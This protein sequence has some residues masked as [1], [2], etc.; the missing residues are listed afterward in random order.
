MCGI[1]DSY[2]NKLC[3]PTKLDCP[4]N[5]IFLSDNL[6][7]NNTKLSSYSTIKLQNLTVYYS[8]KE[9]TGKIING[10]FVD[11]DLLLKYKE[12]CYILDSYPLIDLIKDNNMNIYSDID[13][14]N[15]N[16]DLKS[17]LKW[18]MPFQNREIDLKSMKEQNQIFKINNT[19]N[20]YVINPSKNVGF[21]YAS[22]FFNLLMFII[23]GAILMAKYS[24]KDGGS[25]CLWF[26]NNMTNISQFAVLFFVFSFTTFILALNSII[27][28]SKIDEVVNNIR[29][30]NI[31]YNTVNFTTMSILNTMFFSLNFAFIGIILCFFCVACKFKSSEKYNTLI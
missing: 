3:L 21:I 16:S 28:K 10:L 6:N 31:D 11:S 19:I 7:N 14:S 24:E 12:G 27:Y 23:L 1:L 18:C 20:T 22:I 5:S 9:P 30:K 4:I 17:Y 15:L 26:Q 25:C 13:T 2:G 29:K 8:N